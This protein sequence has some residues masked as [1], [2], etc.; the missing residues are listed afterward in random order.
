MIV[1]A[2]EHGAA[3]V[4]AGVDTVFFTGSVSTGRKVQVQAAEHGI[5]STSSSVE[6]TPPWS[7]RMP[8]ERA[9]HGITW[10]AFGFAGQNCAAVERCYVRRLGL[11]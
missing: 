1:G 11:R 8:T 5:T 3:I 7:W 10:A 4:S 6:R 2:G 9:A